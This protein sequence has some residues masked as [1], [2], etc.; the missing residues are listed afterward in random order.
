MLS[1]NSVCA[2]RSDSY[3]LSVAFGSGLLGNLT[4]LA[5]SHTSL[6]GLIPTVL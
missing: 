4:D 1:T 3:K 6:E 2:L 5:I